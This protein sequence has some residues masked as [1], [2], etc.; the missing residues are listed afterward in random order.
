MTLI[1]CWLTF[2]TFILIGRRRVGDY[3]KGGLKI[4]K[5]TSAEKEDIIT[6]Q[7]NGVRNILKK[8]SGDGG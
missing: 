1:C 6:L 4:K 5:G 2:S 8:G 7:N 3:E